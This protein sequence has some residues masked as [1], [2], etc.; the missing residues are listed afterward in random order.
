MKPCTVDNC[1]APAAPRDSLCPRHRERRAALGRSLLDLHMERVTYAYPF[2]NADS[3]SRQS[4]GVL[5][6]LSAA[7]YVCA[8]LVIVA[9]LALLAVPDQAH[10]DPA[11]RQARE[12]RP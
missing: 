8:G 4:P 3:P 11:G 5:S 6:F 1:S 9:F 2:E 10:R 7:T 12:V